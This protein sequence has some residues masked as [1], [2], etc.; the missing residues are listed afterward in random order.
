VGTG[1]LRLPYYGFDKVPFFPVPG[2][3]FLEAASGDACHPYAFADGTSRCVPSKFRLVA[4]YDLYYKS[5]ACSGDLIH[6]WFNACPDT[7]RDP[8]GIIIR[9]FG[10]AKTVTQAL[11]F[12]GTVPFEGGLFHPTPFVSCQDSGFVPRDGSKWFR[13]TK[14]VNPADRFIPFE[15]AVGD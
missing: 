13:A 3:P 9:P 1:S 6:P 8:V 11:E 4:D 15:L 2:A 7:L 14:P 10:C 5:A 12:D